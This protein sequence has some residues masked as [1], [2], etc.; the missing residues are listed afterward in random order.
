MAQNRDVPVYRACSPLDNKDNFLILFCFFGGFHQG[1][2]G[3]YTWLCPGITVAGSWTIRSTR[4]WTQVG[5]MQLSPLPTVLLPFVPW[6][7]CLWLILGSMFTDHSWQCLGK[8][9]M[10]RTEVGISHM[11]GTW[12]NPCAICPDLKQFST[13]VHIYPSQ[14]NTN[15]L[16][17]KWRWQ[18]I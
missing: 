13:T 1:G 9:V 3:A 7:G 8:H 12:L 14:K 18:V 11:Q 5:N 4:D 16:K 10:S 2:F 17:R 15:T 6:P